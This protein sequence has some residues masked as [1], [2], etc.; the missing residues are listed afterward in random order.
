MKFAS[1]PGSLFVAPAHL[2]LRLKQHTVTLECG[3]DLILGNNGFIWLTRSR[4]SSALGA[5]AE[6]ESLELESHVHATTPTSAE[7]RLKICRVRNSIALLC[8]LHAMISPE[9]IMQIYRRSEVMG[10][11][12]KDILTSEAA[13]GIFELT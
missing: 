6:A 8:Q 7:D 9:S 10:L 5:E 1:G 12:P 3:V 2:V 11:A 4:G 13:H